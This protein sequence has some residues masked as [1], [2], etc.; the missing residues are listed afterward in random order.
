M[1]RI[2]IRLPKLYITPGDA[3]ELS[4]PLQ[5]MGMKQAFVAGAADFTGIAHPSPRGGRLFITEV[6][7]KAFVA[8][9][10]AGTEATAATAAAFG[11]GGLG[12]DLESF[13]ANRPFLFFIRDSTTHLVLF[14]GR[15]VDPT[16]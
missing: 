15:I 5:A 6:Y 4:G 13:N 10:E 12:L 9:D 7:H 3:V 11:A 2:Q 16:Q 8:M 1:R 14:A